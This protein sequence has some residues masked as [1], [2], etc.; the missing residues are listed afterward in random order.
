MLT[1]AHLSDVHLG[2]LPPARLWTLSP[3]QITGYANWHRGRKHRHLAAVLDLIL[4]DIEAAGADHVA[5]TGDLCN[6]G[7]KAEIAEGLKWLERLGPPDRVTVVPGNH[8]AYVRLPDDDGVARWA[9]Y[10]S[11]ACEHGVVRK[12]E[13]VPFPFVRRFGPVALVG[14]SSA[15]PTPMFRATGRLGSPQR[16]GAA[17]VLRALGLEGLVRVV[18]IHHPPLPGHAHRARRLIDAGAFSEVLRDAGAELVLH[19]HNHRSELAFTQTAAGRLPIVGVPSASVGRHPR[20]DRGSYN[21][22]R[23]EPRDGGRPRITMTGRAVT[24]D[25]SRVETIDEQVILE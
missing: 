5:V 16:E 4:A 10:M 12:G 14:L 15:V 13:P 8:D 25:L 19:G 21:L 22:Y 18:L 2:P 9:A 11:G 1:I 17:K 6:I 20:D 23:I 3:K 7:L 24:E